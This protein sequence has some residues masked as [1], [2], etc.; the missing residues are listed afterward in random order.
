MEASEKIGRGDFIQ[1]LIGN[2]LSLYATGGQG[3]G[4]GA[5]FFHSQLLQQT[6]ANF[7]SLQR[8]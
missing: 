8:R 4:E 6:T 1:R 7:P 5:I 3:Q 2:A